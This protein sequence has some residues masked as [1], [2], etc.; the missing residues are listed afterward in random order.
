M[1]LDEEN[2]Y[3][4]ELVSD[5]QRAIVKRYMNYV[6]KTIGIYTTYGDLIDILNEANKKVNEFLKKDLTLAYV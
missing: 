1:F 5:K 6:Y 4:L 3:L 2:T